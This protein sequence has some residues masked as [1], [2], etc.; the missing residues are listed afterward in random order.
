VLELE[1]E[2]ELELVV[3]VLLLPLVVLLLR[4]FTIVSMAPAFLCVLC[5]LERATN[6]EK[7]AIGIRSLRYLLRSAERPLI[8]RAPTSF[9]PGIRR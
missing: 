8:T 4:S 7:P 5:R 6:P 2:L 3:A 9:G 1:L